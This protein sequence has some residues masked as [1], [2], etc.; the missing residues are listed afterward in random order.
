MMRSIRVGTVLFA[1]L[2]AAGVA[3]GKVGEPIR[4]FLRTTF[5]HVKQLSEVSTPYQRALE[6][7]VGGPLARPGEPY[8]ATDSVVPGPVLPWTRF[9]FAGVGSR[10]AFVV[11]EHGGQAPN[12]HLV[13]LIDDGDD[14][15]VS[16]DCFSATLPR[17]EELLKEAVRKGK[18]EPQK[19]PRKRR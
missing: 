4:A 11:Y 16:Y 6:S 12:E 13:I 1:T 19:P 17:T 14:A 10:I 5:R 2:A 8:Q 9:A 18:C 15:T 3:R 7:Y